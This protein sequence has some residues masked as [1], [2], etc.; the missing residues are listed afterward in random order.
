[1]RMTTLVSH[2]GL[3]LGVLLFMTGAALLVWTTRRAFRDTE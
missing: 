2:A 1:M 3:A